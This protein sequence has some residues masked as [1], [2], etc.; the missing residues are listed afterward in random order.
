MR[1]SA[2][3]M[4]G[5]GLCSSAPALTD[6]PS[7]TIQSVAWLAGSWEGGGIHGAPAVEAYSEPA[8]G[9]MIGHFRQLRPD[10]SILFY[11]LITLSVSG[12]KLQYR[13]KHFNPDLTGWEGKDETPTFTLT[14]TAPDRWVSPELVIERLSGDRMRMTVRIE[15][16]GQTEQLVF[17]FA[18]Q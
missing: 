18:R 2:V 11:E 7:P 15:R 9:Q 5:L 12:G 1:I 3:I 17:D 8:G 16:G 14:R 13:V 6:E 10:G 4:F